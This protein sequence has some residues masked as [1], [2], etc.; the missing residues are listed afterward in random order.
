MKKEIVLNTKERILKSAIK[1]FIDKG[2]YGARMQ[3]IADNAKVNK[4]MLH[5]YF[6]D[7]NT[8]Y[9]KSFEYI[10]TNLFS[11]F[12]S[13]FDEEKP[14]MDKIS[15]FV[16]T[17]ID[18]LAENTGLP[19]IIIRELADGGEVFKNVISTLIRQEPFF[20]PIAF[21]D[22][23]NNAKEKGEIRNIDTVHII[24]NIL[25]MLV[26]YFIA[27]PVINTI[28]DIKPEE[29]KDFI[30]ARKKSIIDFIIHGLKND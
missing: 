19:R 18:F 2:K 24:I 22:H 26:F 1:V 11:R 8:L 25:G 28:W 7:K 29:Q 15:K 6:T 13:T 30:E 4:A 23:I 3:E 17:Y 16:C 12:I 20:I 21:M 14:F 9:E 10:F 27:Q 5:Y